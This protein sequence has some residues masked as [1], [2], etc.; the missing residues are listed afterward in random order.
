MGGWNIVI[1]VVS[2]ALLLFTGWQEYRRANKK[3]VWLRMLA[4]TL[5]V[6]SL[7]S[8]ALPVTISRSILTSR[9]EAVIETEGYSADSVRAFLQAQHKSIP[10]FTLEEYRQLAQ[11][12]YNTLHVFGYGFSKPDLALVEDKQVQ[13]HP[14][15]IDAGIAT[16]SWQP[17]LQ[18]G[19]RLRVQGRFINN[20]S[21][22]VQLVLSGLNTVLDSVTL[23]ASAQTS[24]ELST[25]PKNTGRAVFSLSAVAG[26]KTIEEEL[27]P[28]E[29]NQPDSLAV[30]VIAASPYFENRFLKNWLSQNAFSVTM[31]T[32]ISK[33]KITKAF[34]NTPSGDADKLTASLLD[35]QDVLVTDASA[36][37][38]LNADEQQLVK[39]KVEQGLGLI[40]KTD[41]LVPSAF[42]APA[43]PLY[44]PAVKTQQLSVKLDGKS[45][46]SSLQVEQPV[47]LKATPGMQ[48]VIMDSAAQTVTGCTLYGQGKIVLTT[49][50]NTYSWML[51]G[52]TVAYNNY[53]S[54]VLDEASR[55]HQQAENV[56]MNNPFPAVNQQLLVKVETAGSNP[57][58]VKIGGSNLY[59]K[60]DIALPFQWQGTYWPLQTG[61]QTVHVNNSVKDIYVYDTADWKYISATEKITN[62]QLFV[63][64]HV[65]QATE[66]KTAAASIQEAIPKWYFF[67]V[68]MVC[69]TFL[70]VERKFNG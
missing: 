31:R 66:D 18:T 60:Q 25:V 48:P 45:R 34:L 54:L 41:T 68:L 64:N 10:V 51:A 57:P 56:L 21:A 1:L 70:W 30:L 5:A 22:K 52:N 50:N 6:A 7:A 27:V 40:V 24:F 58:T 3:Y 36:F 38:A 8:M 37:A 4:I 29:V 61:W 69:S 16:A 55:S 26:G 13:F 14:A 59:L 67:L 46:Y 32:T 35:K 11:K 28:F 2:V 15:K 65:K 62:T 43:F 49:L 23:P 17:V 20:T 63:S 44:T 19:E 39:A 12:E 53:W 42:Y 47:Y 33:A 9:G